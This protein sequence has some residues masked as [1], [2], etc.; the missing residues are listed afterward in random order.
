M[1]NRYLEYLQCLK[2]NYRIAVKVDWLNDDE[3]VMFDITNDAYDMSGSINVTMQNG[4]RSTG[5]LKLN[6]IDN[7]FPVS[8]NGLWFNQ[9]IR[10][11]VGIYLSDGEPYYLTKGVFYIKNP[12][13]VYHPN[14]K[15]MTIYLVDKWSHLD[16]SL[17]GNLDGIYQTPIGSNIYDAITALLQTD[18]GNGKPLDNK[19]PLLSS[20]YL[21]KTWQSGTEVY[22]AINTPFTSRIN[23]DGT[24]ADVL[25][26][27]AKMLAAHIYY[28]EDG[29]LVIE[30]TNE[31]ILD[32]TKPVQWE[33]SLSGNE[34]LG[35]DTTYDI[36]KV[37][38]EISVIGAIL[39]GKQAKGL[40]QNNNP[41]S[42][43]SI[44]RI[45]RKCDKPYEDENYWVDEQCQAL[46]EYYLKQ[47]TILQK[48]VTITSAPIFH[49][50]VNKLV[51]VDKKTI[52]RQEK[53]LVSGY[54][55]PLSQ[56]GTMTTTV[57][58]INDLVMI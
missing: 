26:D 57:T 53:F 14:E 15:S 23:R 9:K 17:F 11:N 51:S 34:F 19:A 4:M 24:Y 35:D 41:Y 10:V 1:P 45:G 8:V 38:N 39:N 58:N 48:S 21:D 16:G 52:D 29:R 28:N 5:V 50:G 54:T 31:D 7:K 22:S 32:S 56:V 46:A 55:L 40:A 49:M 18:R 37:Y 36:E 30:P 33:F 3:T 6:N 47:R 12:Q 25:L 20:Y 43:T 27:Y 2:G 44:Q 13:E 42:P